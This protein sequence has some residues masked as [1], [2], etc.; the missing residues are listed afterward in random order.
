M[1]S[2][3]RI[4]RVVNDTWTVEFEA[5]ADE[6]VQLVPGLMK[7]EEGKK[8]Y[9]LLITALKEVNPAVE[10]GMVAQYEEEMEKVREEGR[11]E[12]F[13]RA[14]KSGIDLERLLKTNE[15]PRVVSREEDEDED[16]PAVAV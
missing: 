12:V 16:S 15:V 5:V 6:L 10:K 7:T 1:P 11:K 14:K 2:S 3:V 13:E 8:A 9:N 4:I